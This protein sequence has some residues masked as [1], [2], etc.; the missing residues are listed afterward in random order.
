SFDSADCN[1]SGVNA[2]SLCNP[3]GVAV[4]ASGD[5][6]VADNGNSRVL[7]YNTPLTT[8]ASANMVF[9]Q[10]GSFTST[11]CN[12]RPKQGTPT[13]SNL[14]NPYGVAIDSADNL[15]VADNSNNRVL[16]YN[17]PVTTHLTAADAVFGQNDSF[18]SGG[19][20]LGGASASPASLCGPSGAVVDPGGNLYVADTTNN[21]VLKYQLITSMSVTASLAFG[22]VAVGQTVI[23]DLTVRNSGHA[24]LLISGATSSDSEYAPSGTGTCG[25]IPVTVAPETSCTLAV[26]FTP[27][28]ASARSATLSINDNTATS[29]QHVA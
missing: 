28:A 16:E 20:N 15:W 23:R 19:C 9:G 2:S 22:N 10:G 7:E 13:P 17:T 5:L 1:S 3:S 4:D 29:P 11:G 27:G 14:C 25:P 8:G 24:A 12:F 6:Y 21:R 18:T 26:A